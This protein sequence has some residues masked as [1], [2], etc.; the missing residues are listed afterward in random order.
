MSARRG[1]VTVYPARAARFIPGS[2]RYKGGGGGAALI[3]VVMVSSG[4]VSRRT[5]EEGKERRD[6]LEVDEVGDD[7]K[8]IWE[9]S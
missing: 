6:I 5:V 1:K 4:M 3:V 2:W 9:D 7:S 8:L